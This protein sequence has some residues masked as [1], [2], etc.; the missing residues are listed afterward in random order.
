MRSGADGAKELVEEVL[1][2]AA[3]LKY[4]ALPDRSVRCRYV[5]L[6]IDQAVALHLQQLRQSLAAEPKGQT[7]S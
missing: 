3:L 1:P 7:G 4:L 5:G 2:F 6:F